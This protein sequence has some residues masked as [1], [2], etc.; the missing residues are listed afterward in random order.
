MEGRK[1]K[2]K[3][4]VSLICIIILLSVFN[5]LLIY[6]QR[7]FEIT[8]YNSQVKILENGD[9]QVSE[10]FEY[11]FNGDFNGI[12]RTIGIKGSDGFKYF[13]ASEY[14]PEYKELEYTQSLDA[15]MVT[16][17][18]YDKSSNEKK[19]FLLE[20]QLKNVATLYNDTAEF[21]W[22]FFDKSNTSPIGHIK[23]EIELPVAEISAEELKVFG[24]G[25]L[26]GKVSIQEDGKIVYEVFGL[27]SREMMEARILFPTSMI[28]NSTKII[29]QNKFAEIMKEE[30]EWA[31]QTERTPTLESLVKDWE[32]QI[33]KPKAIPETETEKPGTKGD[34]KIVDWTNYLSDSGDYY[35]VVGI[36]KNVGKDIAAYI[37]VKVIAYDKYKKLVSLEEDYADPLSLSPEQEATFKIMIKYNS[38]IDYFELMVN[39]T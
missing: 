1:I 36:L 16:Y 27:S 19:L 17:K 38:K 6:A 18:I 20:Y 31:K 25:P 11:D 9:I 30:L 7:S 26:D 33:K 4:S 3:L 15:D 8:D 5:N 24:H 10:I 22:K 12:I 2:L 35:Y 28:P 13:K 23:I 39:W 29:N 37:K 14:S 21:Y 34:I 32:S